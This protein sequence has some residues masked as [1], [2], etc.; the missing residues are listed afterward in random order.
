MQ[1]IQDKALV[2]NTRNPERITNVITTSE[3]LGEIS[4]GLYQVLV[5]WTLAAAQRLRTLKIKNVPSPIQKDYRYPGAYKPFAHQK[6]TAE[7]LTLHKKSFC[8]SEAGVG[9][10]GS[11]IWAADYLMLKGV[12]RR[13]LVICPLSIMQ[14]AW[15]SELFKLVPGRSVGIAQGTADKRKR[16]VRG[17]YEF[18]VVNYDGVEI[19]GEEILKD[20][21]FDLVIVDEANALK[22]TTTKRWKTVNKIVGPTTWV[23]MMTGTPAAQSPVDAY[24]LARIV[25]PERVPKFFGT[26]RDMVMRKEGPFRWIPRSG[27]EDTVHNVLQPAIRFTKAE[28][29]DLPEMIYQTRDVEM[30]LQQEK[31][32]H[33][34]K[35]QMTMLAAG[36]DITAVN[37]AVLMNKL[38]QISAGSVYSDGGATVEFDASNRLHVVQEIIEESSN[39]VL[40]F[41]QF[42]HSLDQI[43][44]FLKKHGYSVGMIDGRVSGKNRHELIKRFQNTSDPQILIIQPQAAAHGITLTAANTVIWFSPTTSLENYLQANARIHRQGQVNH[45]LVVHIQGSPVEKKIYTMLQNR[46]DVHMRIVDLYKE[47]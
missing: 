20:G 28:C 35:T 39:K 21:T 30:T 33:N 26:F 45:C 17:D 43:E 42:T 18:I 38:L 36:E 22:T 8:F 14:S 13:V 40:I 19:I 29:L 23:W 31:Y 47:A 10:T 37:A 7:F 5:K 16:I 44:H 41:A 11:A 12:I 32:Y 3:N 9:K 4:D 1:I 15:Q 25:C 34:L 24:G 27:A 46:Q 2:V 6:T